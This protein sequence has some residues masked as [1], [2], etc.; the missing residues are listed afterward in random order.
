MS[1][2]GVMPVSGDIHGSQKTASGLLEL[3]VHRVVSHRTCVKRE[4]DEK[5]KE[6]EWGR[7]ERRKGSI[8]KTN[9]ST[10]Q[11]LLKAV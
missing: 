2:S 4:E 3:E 9:S 10:I 7:R 1:V 11:W 6:K 5:D 8:P